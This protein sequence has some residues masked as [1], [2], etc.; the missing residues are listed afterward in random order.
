[1]G[2]IVLFLYP[3]PNWRILPS[4]LNKKDGYPSKIVEKITRNNKID[5]SKGFFKI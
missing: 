3:I 2:N 5:I 1:M 4:V